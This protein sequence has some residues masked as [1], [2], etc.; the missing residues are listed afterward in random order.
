MR[1]LPHI[2]LASNATTGDGTAYEWHGGR[3]LFTAE[4]TWGGGSAKLQFKTS[5]GTW[6]DYTSGSLSA[7]GMVLF[8]L[9]KC[10]IRTVIAT[11]TATYVYAMPVPI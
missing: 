1:G 10:W 2:T 5:N 7:N 9:P 11:A 3:G 4:A 6:V 8:E